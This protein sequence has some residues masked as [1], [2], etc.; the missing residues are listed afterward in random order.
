M[1]RVKKAS[2]SP[3]QRWAR[4]RNYEKRI[5]QYNWQELKFRRDIRWVERDIR[6][7]TQTDSEIKTLTKIINLFED[8][9]QNWDKNT[10]LRR[11]EI[12]FNQYK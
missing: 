1:G 9:L 10:S 8:M 6:S 11:N 3:R 7:Q 5:M 2:I 12:N 4:R